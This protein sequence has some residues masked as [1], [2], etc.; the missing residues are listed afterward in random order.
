MHD[1]QLPAVQPGS[2]AA[3][4]TVSEALA[5]LTDGARVV[6]GGTDLMIEMDRRIS[7]DVEQLIDITRIAGL[8]EISVLDDRVHLGPL[9]THNRRR[10]RG[11]RESGERHDQRIEGP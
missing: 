6:A 7:G 8:D 1:V 4:A 5:M 10:E 11:D 2:Y 9:V 3:P